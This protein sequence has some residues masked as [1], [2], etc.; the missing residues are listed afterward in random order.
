MYK[1]TFFKVLP[2]ILIIIIF[3]SCGKDYLKSTPVTDQSFVEE[4]DTLSA[5]LDRGW[6]TVNASNPI[7][8]GVWT[9]GL[10]DN[11][12]FDYKSYS[13]KGSSNKFVSCDYTSAESP[14][15]AA[16]TISN[17]LISPA[18][19]FQNGDKIIF[20]TRES[21]IYSKWGDRLQV[22]LNITDTSYTDCGKGT[23]PG[24]FNTV[25][26]DINKT[27]AVGYNEAEPVPLPPYPFD[28]N[29]GFPSQPISNALAYPRQWTR[30]EAG[31]TGIETPVRGRFAFRYFIE[32][33]GT[34]G[35]GEHVSIDSVVFV[36]VNHL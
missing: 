18:L 15:P 12:S 23:D 9:Q 27:S 33:G 2:V 34:N 36:S 25:L 13:P 4:F 3:A 14:A 10:T 30:F 8:N 31:V 11:Q 22:C 6:H 24:K 28:P 7:G 21:D 26:L 5:A 19:T 1:S 32:G 20:Y 29:Q 17:F 16:S 35:L